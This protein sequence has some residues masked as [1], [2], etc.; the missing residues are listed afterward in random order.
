MVSDHHC[1][2]V[3]IHE[4]PT[5]RRRSKWLQNTKSRR[6][7]VRRSAKSRIV[8]GMFTTDVLRN[9]W[10]SRKSF[11]LIFFLNKKCEVTPKSY[12]T[13]APTSRPNVQPSAFRL[14]WWSW[15][16]SVRPS[17]GAKLNAG[18]WMNA[19]AR[20]RLTFLSYLGC[21][22]HHRNPMTDSHG[23]NGIFTYNEYDKL[24]PTSWIGKYTSHRPCSSHGSVMG[25]FKRLAIWW[26]DESPENRAMRLI[27]LRASL[28]TGGEWQSGTVTWVTLGEGWCFL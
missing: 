13:S 23:T 26:L 4:V 9:G 27:E 25:F 12:K 11:P 10:N 3:S 2:V 15:R 8:C 18:R 7:N 22:L 20:R 14:V 6:S 1:F 16:T 24:Q 17:N 19:S 21:R 5:P 28:V